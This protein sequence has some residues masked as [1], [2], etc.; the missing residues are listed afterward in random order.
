MCLAVP[1]KIVAWQ[2]REA[3]FTSA[4]VEF[5]G[6]CRSVSLVCVPDAE[7]GDYVLVHAGMAISRI[8]VQ[9]ASRMLAALAE[10]D[11]DDRHDDR[12]DESSDQPSHGRS[13]REH[14]KTMKHDPAESSANA[15]SRLDE[16]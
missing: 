12:N 1:G 2:E 9:A 11:L 3:P 5:G 14:H 7:L 4:V 15:P 16:P 10:L 6:V 13:D 8:D